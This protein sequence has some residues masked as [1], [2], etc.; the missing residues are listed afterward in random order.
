MTDSEAALLARVVMHGDRDAFE[1]LV[2]RH[3]SP[4]RNFLRRLTRNDVERANDLAQETFIRLYKSIGTYRGQAKFTTWL[5]RIAY[6]T[7]LND[8]RRR[9]AEVEFE[10]ALHSPAPDTALS[11]S[12]EADVDSALVLLTDRQRAVFDLHYKKGMTHHEV[13]SALELPLGTVKSD[14][15]RGLDILREILTSHE[16]K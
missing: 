16:R 2:R 11:P 6:N 3:Q 5:Y 10:E 15:A 14:V 4:L 1:V 13:A 9:V 12:D 8:Q 7:F